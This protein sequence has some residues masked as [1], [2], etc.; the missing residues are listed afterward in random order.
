ML[1]VVGWKH[2]NIRCAYAAM[3][4]QGNMMPQC[5]LCTYT[6]E[7]S[8]RNLPHLSF[9]HCTVATVKT[10]TEQFGWNHC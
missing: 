10:T 8:V 9:C 3:I 2:E 1:A 6:V 7:V 4:M 5:R